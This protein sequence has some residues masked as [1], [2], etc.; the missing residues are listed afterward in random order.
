MLRSSVSLGAAQLARAASLPEQVLAPL[1]PREAVLESWRQRNAVLDFL[2]YDVKSIQPE[3][4]ARIGPRWAAEGA[5]LAVPPT[6]SG[7]LELYRSVE[8]FVEGRGQTIST[9]VVAGVGSSALGS[10]AFAR[11]VAD[12]VGAP[13]A[14]V[15]SGYGL[16]DVVTEALGGFFWFGALNSLR[17]AFEWIDRLTRPAVVKEPALLDEAGNLLLRR[18]LDTRT[19]LALLEHP[20]LSFDLLS[21]HSKGNLVISE[22]LYAL[23]ERHPA[24]A[25][26]LGA[27]TAIVTFS[28]RIAMPEQC[29]TVIDVMGEWD[30]F[31]D[32]NSR[33]DIKVDRSVKGAWHHTNTELPFHLPVTPTLVAMLP[34][35]R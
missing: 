22:A 11:N 17:D 14:A 35:G 25:R 2:F 31:G 29:R 10:A 8:E 12:A 30:W 15:V 7:S 1:P 19:V 6:G 27:S 24:R 33:P 21:G 3:E 34:A 26:A 18:S 13:V 23:A 32:L 9:L 28:A 20:A 5:I 4:A 16:A